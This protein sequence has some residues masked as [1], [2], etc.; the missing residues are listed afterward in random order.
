[1]EARRRALEQKSLQTYKT[2]TDADP[3]SLQDKV[4]SEYHKKVHMLYG[5]SIARRPI[6]KPFINS[7]VDLH[8]NLVEEL[9]K[10]EVKHDTPLKRI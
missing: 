3:S 9:L 4:L 6:N 1:M 2:M 8:N 10:R 7:T 5:E